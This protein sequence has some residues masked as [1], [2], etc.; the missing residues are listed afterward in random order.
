[1]TTKTI[2]YYTIGSY[3]SGFN[4]DELNF[5]S[6]DLANQYILTELKPKDWFVSVELNNLIITKKDRV[7]VDREYP[8]YFKNDPK[9]L[10][11]MVKETVEEDKWTETHNFEGYVG[12]EYKWRE[13]VN[14]YNWNN[15]PQV[16]GYYIFKVGDVSHEIKE[17]SVIFR[18]P[19]YVQFIKATLI[20]TPEVKEDGKPYQARKEE[21]KMEVMSEWLPVYVIEGGQYDSTKY[22]IDPTYSDGSWWKGAKPYIAAIEYYVGE[23][24]L[25][26]V[27]ALNEEIIK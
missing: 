8:V 10:K 19:V 27:T 25:E 7:K 6:R 17:E 15:S 1:M 20:V 13:K 11:K 24:S 23:N 3:R 21:V 22:G 4:S 26:I 2:K 18:A 14:G 12:G 5:E 9:R 16:K